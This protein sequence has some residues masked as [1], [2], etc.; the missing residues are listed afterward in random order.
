MCHRKNNNTQMKPLVPVFKFFQVFILKK[1]IQTTK[2][3]HEQ[4]CQLKMAR[5]PGTVR[6]E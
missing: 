4:L 1:T 3:E 6:C 2:F 5:G